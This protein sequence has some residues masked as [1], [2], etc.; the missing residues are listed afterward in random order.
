MIAARFRSAYW[1]EFVALAALVLLGV[2]V[3]LLFVKPLRCRAL[4]QKHW[5]P[6]RVRT[7]WCPRCCRERQPHPEWMDRELEALV[8]KTRN[9]RLRAKRAAA[10]ELAQTREARR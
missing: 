4:H 5:E 1:P 3:V 9:E 8:C 7:A 2:G 6:T 10:D